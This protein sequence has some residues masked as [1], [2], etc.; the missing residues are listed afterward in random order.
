MKRPYLKIINLIS[1]LLFFLVI[2]IYYQQFN[3]Y[4]QRL[5]FFNNKYIIE[6]ELILD[7]TNQEIKNNHKLEKDNNLLI[8]NQNKVLNN[9]QYVKNYLNEQEKE[10][11]DIIF[12]NSFN[13]NS[14]FSIKPIDEISLSRVFTTFLNDNPEHFWVN[15]LKY[16]IN[17][18]SQKVI[19]LEL[20]YNS[21]KEERSKKQA[22]IDKV[23][24]FIIIELNKLT[25]DYDKV[26]Y[27]YDYIA[28]KT[29]YDLTV[30]DN[31]N[32]YNVLVN[33]HGVC[34]G[35]AKSFQYIMNKIGINTL[36][37]T[38][39]IIKNEQSNPG[40]AWNMVEINNQY[41]HIDA[42]WAN[43][44]FSLENNESEFYNN[45]H[46]FNI[47]DEEIFKTHQPD[48]F[49][50]LPKANSIENNYYYK[51]NLLFDTYNKQL[52]IKILE[53]I[54]NLNKQNKQL[55]TIKFT[56]EEAYHKT[57]TELLTNRN[58]FNI[59][60][61]ANK[62]INFKFNDKNISYYKEDNHLIID[63]ILN[64]QS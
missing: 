16:Y 55:L 19:K 43:V 28:S 12:E 6:K 64:Y 15:N 54:I 2:F 48:M 30:I 61:E 50:P 38:G 37:I 39:K 26:K 3:Q 14:S 41:Y 11:Y 45:Y 10:L 18:V 34:A 4:Q 58:I 62:K 51:E 24:D 42:T 5:F 20:I 23:V 8:D 33:H 29:T 27:V 46:Y 21:N 56:N 53:E 32:M 49:Y 1:L 9:Y 60:R 44:S 35:Y 17:K 63:I 57:F 40:H 7:T 31:Q 47:K 59:I 52:N 13:H 25:T 36:Y 22:Q